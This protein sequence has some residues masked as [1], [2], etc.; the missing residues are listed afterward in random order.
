[1]SSTLITTPSTSNPK[2]CRRAGEL[3]DQ[4]PHVVDGVDRGGRVG[5]RQP[6]GAGPVEELGVGAEL[7]ALDVAEAVDPH[8][9]RALAHLAGVLLAQGTRCRVARVHERRLAALDALLVHPVELLDRVVH[10]AADLDHRGRVVVGEAVGHVVEREQLLGDG[11]P[12]RSRAAGG[13]DGEHA[14]AVHAVDRGAVDLQ[15]AGPAH[16]ATGRQAALHAVGPRPQV[17]LA[18]D[19][20]ERLHRLE[21]LEGRERL[22]ERRPR[23][24]AS[25]SRACAA[26]GTRPRAPRARAGARRT[27]RRAS[28]GRTARSSGTARPGRSATPRRAAP[29]PRRAPKPSPSRGDGRQHGETVATTVAGGVG[30]RGSA[31]APHPRGAGSAGPEPR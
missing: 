1:M 11:L 18:E 3:L 12:H 28:P 27:R 20:V 2:S 23:P 10:L 16:L 13:A 9:Q 24:A 22:V 15:L 17:G 7:A 30:G 4:R 19:V 14:V 29:G 5:H 26:P 8:R 6:G 21:V 25:A 31:G